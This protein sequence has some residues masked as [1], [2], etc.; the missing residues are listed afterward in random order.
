[1]AQPGGEWYFKYDALPTCGSLERFLLH[2]SLTVIVGGSEHGN[3]VRFD[4]SGE[5][6]V[7][8]AYMQHSVQAQSVFFNPRLRQPVTYQYDLS[9]MKQVTIHLCFP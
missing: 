5:Q 4:P 8:A 7:E 6:A 1:M 2:S 9:K 3:W